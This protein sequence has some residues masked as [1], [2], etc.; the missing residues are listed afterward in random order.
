MSLTTSMVRWSIASICLCI[1][2][3]V[4]AFTVQ[5]W[6]AWDRDDRRLYAMMPQ[7]WTFEYLKQ[8]REAADT[9]RE[10]HGQ[11]PVSFGDLRHEE[12]DNLFWLANEEGEPTDEWMSPLIYIPDEKN[13]HIVSFG[14]D[15]QPGGMGF[16]RD[17]SS[18]DEMKLPAFPLSNFLSSQLAPV[19]VK[20]SF[21]AGIAALVIFFITL[22]PRNFSPAIRLP[23][24]RLVM[25]AAVAVFLSTL[26]PRIV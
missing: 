16:D 12:I 10:R 3:M 5:F 15:G 2:V 11:F 25:I 20:M 26:P 9:Y 22:R 14:M 13:P 18:D 1:V 4:I 19:A 21:D 17:L 8:I 6:D 7:R 23:W 24:L